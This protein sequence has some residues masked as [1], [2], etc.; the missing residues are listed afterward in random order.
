MIQKSGFLFLF[1]FFCARGKAQLVPPLRDSA[2][3]AIEMKTDSV[4]TDTTG[5]RLEKD[6]VLSSGILLDVLF[7]TNE[8]CHLF[9][10]DEPRG[11]VTKVAF[12]YLKLSPGTYRYTA[13]NPSTGEEW[14]DTFS[15]AGGKLN[16]VFI[17]L[18]YAMDLAREKAAAGKT[19]T[20]AVPGSLQKTTSPNNKNAFGKEQEKA[21]INAIYAGMLPVKGGS[22]VMGNNR[23]PAADE[24]EHPVLLK[25]FRVSRFEVSQEQWEAVMG[26]NPSLNRGCA[27]CPVENVSW[28]DVMIF[29][30]RLNSLTNQR[31][32]L[33]T[34]AEWEYVAKAG[35]KA[36]IDKAGGTEEFIKKTAWNFVNSNG[37]TQPVGK[38]QPN[39][40][41]LY[42]L[43]G[44]V[45][46]WCM[47]W[48]GAFF[49][50]EDFTEKNPEG[51]PLG[52]EK[53]VRGGNYKDYIGDRF[54]PS[55]R[56]KLNPK[57]KSSQVG[58]RLAMDG[59][60]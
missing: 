11:F 15:V 4:L 27:A 17:D 32:R 36:E 20:T 56:N 6:S 8:D 44:N 55:F 37:Q 14:K 39:V 29:I 53:I 23:S 38:K 13:R 19:V 22:F 25:P 33:P 12:F 2:D 28:E 35:G 10:N 5:K 24:A 52:K 42:D 16:E 58:F 3:S 60:E 59:E 9:I 50:K 1:L 54:R 7:A 30:R 31:Y 34:E 40:L 18:L 51:P 57:S 49:Y 21:V 45:S 43:T 26:S 48:Y 47:D 46:E 41:G